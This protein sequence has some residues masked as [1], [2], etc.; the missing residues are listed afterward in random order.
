MLYEEM[1][2]L[3]YNGS[4][5]GDLSLDNQDEASNI[6]L[7]TSVTKY[8]Y[9]G[10]KSP[11]TS[12]FIY[13]NTANAIASTLD[14]EY[15]DGT[16]WRNVADKLDGTATAGV[17]FAKSG[18][19]KWY[20][21]NDHGWNCVGDTSDNGAPAELS[22]IKIYNMYW[23]RISSADA[24]TAGANAK[25]LAYTFTSTQELNN[26]DVEISGFYESFA[27]GKTDWIR[28]IITAS[29]LTLMEMKRRGVIMHQGQLIDMDDFTVPASFKAL[30]L[31]Y[32]NLGPSYIERR[33]LMQEEFAKALNVQRPVID[34]NA[35]GKLDSV[36][37]K[38]TPRMLVR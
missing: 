26:Y 32:S 31:I 27:T 20:L 34:S 4:S 9:V 19:I 15:W 7:A 36:E 25:Q 2:V 8:I 23:M 1:R 33:K 30:E 14:V 16:Q 29:K 37:E 21:D 17:P 35:D 38:G 11:F 10:Q 12:L 5:L 13:L 24:L 22:S 6:T 18:V 3:Y 28:E